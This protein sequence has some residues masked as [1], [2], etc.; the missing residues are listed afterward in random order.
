M[1]KPRPC[2]LYGTEVM[3]CDN[4][5]LDTPIPGIGIKL[6]YFAD[7]RDA[8]RFARWLLRAAAWARAEDKR[9]KK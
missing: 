5:P 7:A 3:Y 4:L 1:R 8:E 9:R 6:D 2:R